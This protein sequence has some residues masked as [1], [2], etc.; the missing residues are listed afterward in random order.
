MILKKFISLMRV[1]QYYKNLVI[2]LSIIFANQLTN[3]AG[4]IRTSIG[5][6][7]LCFISSA[8]YI[9]NDLVDLKRDRGHPEKKLRPLASGRVRMW[10]ALV[11]A[12]LLI[13]LS[14][15]IA[16]SLSIPFFYFVVLLLSLTQLYSFFFKNIPFADVIFIAV[17]FIIRAIS[18]VFVMLING[19]P[20]LRLS[21][22]LILCTFFLS[23]FISIGKRESELVL[24][25]RKAQLHKEVLRVYTPSLTK[26][27]MIISS[28][29]LIMSYSFYT[30]LSINPY[31]ILTLPF[32]LYVIFRY[33]YLIESGSNI[34]R[35][36]ERFIHDKS[37]ITGILLWVLSTVVLLYFPKYFS[38]FTEIIR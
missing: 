25:G 31:L 23:L 19:K 21:P 1:R 29:S 24:L 38:Y 28:T 34:A 14:F 15:Y 32:S 33:L 9:I 11:L 22:W 36:P 7:S 37:L 12:T 26:T 16:I 17:N 6:L 8:N 5:F 4:L 3:N 35:H 2:F 13:F 18:G 10:Q 30:F 27:L 20:W